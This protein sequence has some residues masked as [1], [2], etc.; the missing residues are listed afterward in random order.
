[1]IRNA[2]DLSPDQKT[3]IESLLGRRVLEDE[4]ISVRAIQ[5]PALSDQ[6]RQELLEQL[7]KYFAE[8]DARRKPASAEE[9]EEIL[10]EAIRSTRP[11]YRPRQ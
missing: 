1:M 10:T 6:R 9:A 5:R 4:D 2:K 7:R 11:G 3:A 8:V